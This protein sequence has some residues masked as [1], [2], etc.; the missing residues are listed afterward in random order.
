MTEAAVGKN[1]GLNTAINHDYHNDTS[2]YFNCRFTSL[3]Y[4]YSIKVVSVSAE[5]IPVISDQQVSESN[6]S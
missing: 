6:T 4:D 5:F 1:Q 2:R 3:L